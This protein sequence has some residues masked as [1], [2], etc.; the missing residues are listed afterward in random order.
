MPIT[1][2]T[3]L[4]HIKSQLGATTRP[5]PISDDDILNVVIEETLPTFSKYYPYFYKLYVD[6]KTDTLESSETRSVYVMNTQGME[7]LGVAQVYRTDGAAADN[8]YPYYNTNNIFD[9]AIAN[10]YLS[11]ASVPETFS[12]YPPSII[13]LYPKNFSQNKF[14]VIAKCVHLPSFQSIPMKLKDEFFELATIDVCIALYPILKHYDQLN[15]PFGT[16]DLK[17][18][19]LEDGQSKR[20][21]LI[22]KFTSKFLKEAERKKI[23]I[24]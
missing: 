3:L 19:D 8:R 7:V 24:V 17:I 22:E 2:T 12:F 23:W 10:N 1:P 21:E 11:V 4:R 20:N 5:L 9:I 6:P 14:L 15:T 13:E 16:I 18:N